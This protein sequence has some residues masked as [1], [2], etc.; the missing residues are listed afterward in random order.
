[1]GSTCLC[2][3]IYKFSGYQR[4]NGKS[5]RITAASFTISSKSWNDICTMQPHATPE[6]SES[7]NITDCTTRDILIL[8]H[9]CTNNNRGKNTHCAIFNTSSQARCVWDHNWRNVRC[10]FAEF[11]VWTVQKHNLQN[12]TTTT[13]AAPPST[14]KF[15]TARVEMPSICNTYLVN[16]A[17]RVLSAQAIW[18]HQIVF[19]NHAAVWSKKC[20]N[21]W[22]VSVTY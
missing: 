20:F 18:F 19:L 17:C 21:Q 1:M 3:G 7:I 9:N 12:T 16:L 10:L 14:I 11:A 2:T 13:A 15:T 8:L 6:L 5:T 22:A 4:T